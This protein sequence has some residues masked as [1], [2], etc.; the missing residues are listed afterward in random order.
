MPKILIADD[1]AVVRKGFKQLLMEDRAQFEVG[2]ACTGRETLDRLR[3]QKWDL[4]VLDINMPDRSGIDILRQIH[5]AY[6]GMRV[7]IL[8]AFPERQYAVNV[9]RS[10]ANGYLNKEMA[11]EE[12]LTAVKTVLSGRRYVSVALAELL[13]TELDNDSEKPAHMQLSEREFQI[14]CKLASGTSVSAI[15]A[16]LCLSVKTISTYRSRLME[17]MGFKSNADITA[18]ALRNQLIN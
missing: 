14:F 4:L 13:V 6:P 11:P 12:L 18:Y 1:H 7:L 5:A 3:E 10:G 16:E 2:E 17:K 15:G 9:L 8:S